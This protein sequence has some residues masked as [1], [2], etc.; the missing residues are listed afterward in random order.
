MRGIAR[1]H[2]QS[3]LQQVPP[4]DCDGSGLFWGHLQ[5]RGHESQGQVHYHQDIKGHRDVQERIQ[6]PEKIDK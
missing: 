4:Q 6:N 3:S 5:G 1:S 2:W